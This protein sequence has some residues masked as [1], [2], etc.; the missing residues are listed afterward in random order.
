MGISIGKHRLKILKL[1]RRD[2]GG[3]LGSIS[4]LILALKKTKKSVAK[5]LRSWVQQ[6]EQA[7]VLVMV[8]RQPTSS[9]LGSSR[10]KKVMLKRSKKLVMMREGRLMLTNGNNIDEP[11]VVST[12]VLDSFCGPLVHD[13]QSQKKYNGGGDDLDEEYWTPSLE[14]IRWDAMFEDPDLKPT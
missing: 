12:P 6:E 14:E 4:K 9:S 8:P 1:G 11:L 13:L 3:G 5:C 7:R 10:W 2:K